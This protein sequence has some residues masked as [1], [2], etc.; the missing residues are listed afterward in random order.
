MQILTLV[1]ILLASLFFIGV[2]N[3]TKSFVSGRK[4][5]NPWQPLKDWWRL[6]RKSSIY[7]RDTSF[8]FQIAPTISFASI[9]CAILVIPFDNH[10]GLLSFEGDFVFFAYILAT[11]KFFLILG[12][13][14]TGS[15]FE[16]MGANREA[17]YSLL[18]EP[19]LFILLGSLAMVTDHSSFY[20]IF[21]AMHFNTSV[22]F[23]IGGLSAYVLVQVAM[24]ENSRLPIDDPKTHLELT[25]VHE[26]MVLDH[27]GFDL[28]M[29]QYANALKFSMYGMLIFNFLHNIELWLPFKILM[30]FGVQYVFAV[31]IGLLESFRAR[32]AMQRN[33]E[34][35]F[36]LTAMSIL[37][38]FGA[39]IL[40]NKFSI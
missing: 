3:Q 31:L 4:S 39:L 28:A 14:D 32:A 22:S 30:Y 29:L 20:D 2:I 15:S 17:L 33:P 36:V 24:I 7:S 21:T 27:S 37:I 34:V 11:G 18:V 6:A 40:M 23:L 1:L 12:A 25:M 9:L 13:L 10:K 8:I 26:V 5:P 35:I 19:A 16:G 38:F